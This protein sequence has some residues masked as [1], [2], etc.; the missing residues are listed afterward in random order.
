MNYLLL[1]DTF[2]LDRWHKHKPSLGSSNAV[3]PTGVVTEQVQPD[4]VYIAE[5]KVW[6]TNP[7]NHPYRI[8]FLRYEPDSPVTPPVRNHCHIAYTVS[9]LDLALVGKRTLLGPFDALDGLRVVFIEE[10]GAVI[11]YMHFGQGRREIS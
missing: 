9:D 8:E 4:E 7:V 2:P 10:H 3:S 11:E 5:T 6:V 1:T